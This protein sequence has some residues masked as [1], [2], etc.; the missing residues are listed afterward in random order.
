MSPNNRP[1]EKKD[2]HCER[3]I[4][5]GDIVTD[6]RMAAGLAEG[7]EDFDIVDIPF[8]IVLSQECDLEQDFDVQKKPTEN[9]DKILPTIL[10]CPAYNLKQFQTG[11]HYVHLNGRK[12]RAWTSGE[13]TK[14]T[15]NTQHERYHKLIEDL[16]FSIPELIIDFKH[17]YT[18]PRDLMYSIYKNGY[19]ASTKPLFREHISRRFANYLSRIGLPTN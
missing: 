16:E 9:G 8:A 3:R 15:S 4:S 17:F 10:V 13:A 1:Y 2:S 6:L 7:S 11:D 14:L 12:M 18:V 5:Q 19:K